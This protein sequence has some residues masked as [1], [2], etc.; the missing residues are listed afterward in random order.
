MEE[1]DRLCDRIAIIDHGRLITLDTPDNLKSSV[2]GANVETSLNVVFA[3]YAGRG[4]PDSGA[5]DEVTSATDLRPAK[6]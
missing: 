3:Y 6:K 4:L 1:A 5:H 2:P